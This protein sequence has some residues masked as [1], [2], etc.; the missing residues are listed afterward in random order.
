MRNVLFA[1]VL[2][3]LCVFGSNC[4]TSYAKSPDTKGMFPNTSIP[5]VATRNDTVRDMLWLAE[6]GKDDVVYDLGSGD[7]RIVISAI[8]DFAAQRAVGIEID[9]N[10]IN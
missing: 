3:A 2:M 8:R 4:P 9:P 5:F 6:V 7:G 10:H 1:V